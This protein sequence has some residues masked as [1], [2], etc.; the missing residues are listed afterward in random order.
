VT[1]PVMC[2]HGR[3]KANCE[4]EDLNAVLAAQRA[5]NPPGVTVTYDHD[6]GNPWLWPQAAQYLVLS[7]LK[8]TGS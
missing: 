3:T 4:L 7:T 1:A 6:P 2:S 8:R 5:A